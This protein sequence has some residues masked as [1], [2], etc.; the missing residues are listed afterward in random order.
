VFSP[1]S[2]GRAQSFL[3]SEIVKTEAGDREEGSLVKEEVE[4]RA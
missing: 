4:G 2:P 3:K 1:A